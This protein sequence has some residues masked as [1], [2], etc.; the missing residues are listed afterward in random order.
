MEEYS[1][2][3]SPAAQNDFLTLMERICAQSDQEAARYYELFME[4][5]GALSAKPESCPLARDAQLRL[6]GYRMLTVEKYI[7]F[8]VIGNRNNVEFR[9]ILYLR[10]QYARFLT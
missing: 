3:I 1:I 4:K 7:V 9:R 2:I 10:R 6:R 5:A 8:Y